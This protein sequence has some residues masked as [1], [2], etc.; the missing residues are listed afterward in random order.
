MRL[1]V[2]GLSF[3]TTEEGLREAFSQFG[4]LKR[5]SIVMDRDTARSKGFGFVEFER[6]EDSETAMLELHGTQLDGRRLNIEPAT[7]KRDPTIVR[8]PVSPRPAPQEVEIHTKRPAANKKRTPPPEAAFN[9]RY[10]D[11]E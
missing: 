4:P 7:D 9:E 3:S 5:I 1:F 11:E 8:R 10:R 6:P 2:G